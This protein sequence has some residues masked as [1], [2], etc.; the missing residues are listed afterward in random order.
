MEN[1]DDLMCNE[2]EVV[3]IVNNTMLPEILNVKHSVENL[4]KDIKYVVGSIKKDTDKQ[5]EEIKELKSEIQ[6]LRKTLYGNGEDT[7]LRGKVELISEWV[8]S[9]KRFESIVIGALI[10]QMI[11]WMI[12]IAQHVLAEQ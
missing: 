5:G 12:L 9:R 10:V 8:Q 1:K 4:E 3:K 2:A 11:G 7:G 6:S